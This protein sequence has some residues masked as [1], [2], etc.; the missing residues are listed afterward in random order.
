M[1]LALMMV[2]VMGGA[3]AILLIIQAWK[4]REYRQALGVGKWLL[5]GIGVYFVTLLGFSVTSNDRLVGSDGVQFCSLDGDC[6]MTGAIVRVERRKTA[7]NPPREL[8]ANGM[9]YVVTAKVSSSEANPKFRPKELT[10]YMVDANGKTYSRRTQAE[11]E[12]AGE[13][14]TDP[15]ILYQIVSGPSGGS[16]RKTMVFDVPVGVQEP[17]LVLQQGSWLD[18]MM[19]LFLVGDEDSMLH[20]KTKLQVVVSGE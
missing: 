8:T 5:A 6:G 18:R 19:Q 20:G 3:Y 14:V 7:G 16:Y 4:R 11:W 13:T 9:F 12:V 17:A 10:G 15:A 2:M 1:G